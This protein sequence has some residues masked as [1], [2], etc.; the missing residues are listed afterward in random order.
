MNRWHRV[1]LGCAVV[2]LVLYAAA[3]GL[4]YHKM[5]QPPEA[6]GGFL[7]HVP[8]PLFALFPFESMWNA[9]RGGTLEVGQVAPDFSLSTADRAATVSLSSFRGRPVALVFGSYT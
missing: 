6:V 8:M 2:V 3:L 7:K 4:I 1:L 9:A 5:G